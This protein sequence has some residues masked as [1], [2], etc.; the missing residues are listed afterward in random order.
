MK[1]LTLL[2]LPLLFIFPIVNDSF[3]SHMSKGRIALEGSQQLGYEQ[4]SFTKNANEANLYWLND[5]ATYAG[6]QLWGELGWAILNVLAWSAAFAMI[7]GVRPALFALLTTA[8]YPVLSCSEHS[9]IFI[10]L[11][12]TI[13]LIRRNLLWLILPVQI[14]WANVHPSFVFVPLTIFV[15]LWSQHKFRQAIYISLGTLF[16]S[17]V[18]PHPVSIWV[19]ALQEN[20]STTNIALLS[21]PVWWALIA[22]VIAENHKDVKKI[23]LL[24]LLAAVSFV[25]P[26]WAIATIFLCGLFLENSLQTKRAQLVVCAIYLCVCGW[27]V[28]QLSQMQKPP[29]FALVEKNFTRTYNDISW[30]GY[31]SFQLNKPIF[32]DRHQKYANTVHNTTTLIRHDPTTWDD[33]VKRYDFDSA[34]IDH[35]LPYSLDLCRT[36]INNSLWSLVYC[37]E[38]FAVYFKNA[39]EET[40]SHLQIE[41][42]EN[43]RCD[44][45]D[46]DNLYCIAQFYFSIN[47]SLAART[48]M[49]KIP[50]T[51]MQYK[52]LQAYVANDEGELQ[53][54]AQQCAKYIELRNNNLRELQFLIATYLRTNNKDNFAAVRKWLKYA[55][56]KY[57]HNIEIDFYQAQ[58]FHLEE[59]YVTALDVLQKITT[60]YPRFRK[61][62]LYYNSIK[63]NQVIVGAQEKYVKQA[64]LLM[65]HGKF[66][67]ALKRLQQVLALD[68]NYVDALLEMGKIY[69][70]LKKY[71]EAKECYE[72]VLRLVPKHKE[73]LSYLAITLTAMGKWEE[74]KKTIDPIANEEV[75]YIQA[76]LSVVNDRVI[77]EL[78]KELREKHS[79]A[80]IVRLSKILATEKRFAEAIKNFEKL[81]QPDKKYLSF[82]YYEQ[83]KEL[84]NSKEADKGIQALK[85][86]IENNPQHL[87]AHL[88]I[89]TIF[90]KT[91][92]WKKAR[93]HYEQVQSID[94]SDP[95]AK[96]GFALVE[97]GIGYEYQ[98]QKKYKQTVKHFENFVAMTSDL[99]EKKRIQQRVEDLKK[100][101]ENFK[102]IGLR[103]LAEKAENAI[104]R[105]DY[106]RA[107]K[108][109]KTIISITDNAPLSHYWLAIFCEKRGEYDNAIE[110]IQKAL[111]H[112]PLYKEAHFLLSGLYHKIGKTDLSVKHLQIYR[113]QA[114][115]E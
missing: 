83:G 31:L 108:I 10:L 28:V 68:E 6:Y 98:T 85:K 34:I 37:N 60:K 43:V 82:L 30:G 45:Q 9:I 67:L 21:F 105:K 41:D 74:A 57:P 23:A 113:E 93:H 3:Y 65:Q 109:H 13:L 64:R 4:I 114:K 62:Q 90:L 112:K 12:L 63:Q 95:R 25:Y 46:I 70:K 35:R 16:C 103:V 71:S 79:A 29:R 49:N 7:F 26:L 19:P 51:T 55:M 94:P 110:H 72:R 50:A 59:D 47:Y 2:L 80:T 39:S 76:A 22:T 81:A 54:A 99:E 36:L 91:K 107:E 33:M 97:L 102:I 104:R 100:S 5:I 86:A 20:W 38:S 8:M 58:L 52:L 32:I 89:G 18:S 27:H 92:E 14:L 40:P 106:P 88:L 66:K 61:A 87:E 24:L 75:G 111:Q 44:T 42:D 53:K 77:D 15:V 69:H 48:I 17:F 1:N 115:K 78:Y 84:L 96:E 101:L 73:A 56:E 11:A